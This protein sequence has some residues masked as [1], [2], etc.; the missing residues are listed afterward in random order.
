MTP[1]AAVPRRSRRGGRHRQRRP[2]RRAS[3][4]RRPRQPSHDCLHIGHDRRTQG[5]DPH[6]R[7]LPRPGAQHRGGVRRDRARGRQHGDLLAARARARARTAADLSRER[8]AH[9]AP[10]RPLDRRRD[11]RHPAPDVPRGGAARAAEDHRRRRRESRRP[12]SFAGVE[13]RRAH[14]VR[15]GRPAGAGR[16]GPCARAGRA[17]RHPS[18]VLRPAVLRAAA[19]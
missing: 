6:A 2:A 12:R 3:R 16:R 1:S 18:H 7:E 19:P 17:P 13:C 10:R 9:R 15:V 14:G 11:A 4:S 5:R 8:H